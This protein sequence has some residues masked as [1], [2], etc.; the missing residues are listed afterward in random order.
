MFYVAIVIQVSFKEDELE[1]YNKVRAHSSPGAFIKDVLIEY[2]GQSLHEVAV[3]S[4][5]RNIA[6]TNTIDTI[7]GNL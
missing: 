6:H 5:K 3:T 2:Y 4:E 1:L 7:L